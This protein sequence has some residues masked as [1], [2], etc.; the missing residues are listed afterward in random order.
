[1]ERVRVAH[2]GCEGRRTGRRAPEQGLEGTR[3]SGEEQGLDER[4]VTGDRVTEIG[5]RPRRGR[6]APRDGAAQDTRWALADQARD[7][8]LATLVAAGVEVP[9]RATAGF[10]GGT[11]AVVLLPG[12]GWRATGCVVADAL[13]PDLPLVALDYPRRWPREGLPSI[14]ALAR[15]GLAALDALGVER[16]RLA[17]VS[18]GGMVALRMALDAPSRVASLALVSTAAWGGAVAGPGRLGASLA[19][20][21][22]LPPGP[23]GAFYR[24]FGPS[25]V[26]LRGHVADEERPRL[27]EDPMTRRKMRDLLRGI[28]DLDLRP[29][30]AEIG[31]P[32]LVVHGVDDHI[33]PLREAE[34]LARG[35]PRARL[36]AIEGAGHFA[37]VTR[38]ARVV[39]ELRRFWRGETP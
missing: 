10:A 8:T 3:G 35:L 1:V 32:A 5:A 33:F 13:G 30:L 20:A 25:L 21:G 15:I 26:G 12:L 18:T 16:A 27:W 14:D 31:A 37:F 23:F 17:G 11:E 28:R 6:A 7:S 4:H 19:L 39:E 34:A 2:D 22:V 9:W 36:A 24:R 29:R 38:R